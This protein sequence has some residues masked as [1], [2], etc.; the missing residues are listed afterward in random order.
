MSTG[1]G[2]APGIGDAVAE[3]VAHF[4]AERKHAAKDFA[5]RSEVVLRDPLSKFKELGGKQGRGVKDSFDS[6]GF[7]V[8]GR[9]G[10]KGGHES[11]EFFV[12]EGDNDAGSWL[13]IHARLQAVGEGP[14]K[15][16]RERH[17]A[18]L[19]EV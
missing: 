16:N 7:E 11:D 13:Y 1:K 2:V 9:I 19:R 18:I 14:V 5:D 4:G 3:S 10:M 6:F 8:G 17:F 12:A 15:R